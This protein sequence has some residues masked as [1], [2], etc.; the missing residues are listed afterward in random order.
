MIYERLSQAID[1][2]TPMELA[3]VSDL[4]DTAAGTERAAGGVVHVETVDVAALCD[5]GLSLR[6]GVLGR[7]E[8]R[9]AAMKAQVLAEVGRRHSKGDAQRMVRNE[10]QASKREAK[11][12]VESAAQ[13]AE[14]P[15]TSEALASGE[16]PPGHA[17]L[18][19]RASG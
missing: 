5:E 19:A 15:A 7:A 6:L 8:S 10:L 12:D 16:I 14:L 3:P 1:I 18:I 4:L 17:R 9:L 13:L 11:R 2:V